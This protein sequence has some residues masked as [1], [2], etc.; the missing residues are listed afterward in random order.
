[1][2]EIFRF[3]NG[4]YDVNVCRKDDILESIN[5]TDIDKDIIK[6]VVT[7]CELDAINF[8]NDGVW[9]G[10]PYVGNFRVPEN[11]KKFEENNCKELLD[12]AK[13]T[14]NQNQYKAF[15]KELNKNIVIE[16]NFERFYKFLT[17]KFVNKHKDIY[18]HLFNNNK[19]NSV[20]IKSCFARIMCYSYNEL[21]TYIPE[22]YLYD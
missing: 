1:M 20:E 8:I 3:P 18:N 9:A 22:E 10:I 17:S 11:V 16:V 7:Q 13:Q 19:F 12:V 15:R 14:L 5:D 6:A 21:S 4:G 2:S